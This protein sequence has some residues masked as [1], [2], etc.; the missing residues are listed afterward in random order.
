MYYSRIQFL[1]HTKGVGKGEQN[2]QNFSEEIVIFSEERILSQVRI[3]KE[4]RDK[5]LN[6]TV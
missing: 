1:C 5:K 3:D 4:N 2:G 6:S